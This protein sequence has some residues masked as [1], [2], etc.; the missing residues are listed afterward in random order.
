MK[1]SN[2]V[3][4]MIIVMLVTALIM[5]ITGAIVSVFYPVIPSLLFFALGVLLTTCLNIV[6]V[7]WLEKS[8]QKAATMEDPATAGNY[9]R[10]QYLLRFLFTGLVLIF[11]VLVPV[12]D[13]WGALVGI[14][15]FH[16]AKY[17]L[18]LIIK[19]NDENIF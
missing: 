17:S 9:I 2:T 15:T 19:T 1:I 12:I 18:P 3:Q 13:L 8:V 5:I 11:A 16:V 6:K 14:F 7:V 10:L 4:K